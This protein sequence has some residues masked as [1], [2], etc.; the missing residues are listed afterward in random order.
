MTEKILTIQDL[1]CVGE[2]SLTVALPILS[3][4]GFET[5]VL[6][7]AILSEHTLFRNYTFSDLTDNMEKTLSSWEKDGH[8]FSA[9]YT[10]YLGAVGHF[11]IVE[12]IIERCAEPG[13]KIIVDPVFGDNGKLY[14]RFDEDYVSAVR[15]FVS[16]ANVILPN[17]TEACFLLKRPYTES[18]TRESVSSIL[19]ELSDMGGCD[20]VLTGFS[21][22]EKIGFA[23]Y[24]RAEKKTM[25]YLTERAEGNF[26][27]TGDIFASIFTGAYLSGKNLY[28]SAKKA[29]DFTK[30]AVFAT[31]KEHFYGVH[32]ERIL[33]NL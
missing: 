22:N 13:V 2:C 26:H 20:V 8:R 28:E 24:E 16:L 7:T 25:F 18:Y 30:D 33:K 21:E 17:M 3:A 9:I 12:K 4:F 6:P 27:G 19:R 14:P 5:A 15:K 23:S 29:T 11:G 1:S 10:G 31:E 32:F